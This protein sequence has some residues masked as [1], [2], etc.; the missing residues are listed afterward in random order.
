MMCLAVAGRALAAPSDVDGGIDAVGAQ[1]DAL[2]GVASDGTTVA[3]PPES[4]PEE[5]PAFL[6]LSVN[7]VD[8]DDVF[9][10]LR[11]HDALVKV[12]DLQRSG[13]QVKGGKRERRGDDDMV[14]LASLS[15]GV[16]FVTDER[17]LTLTVTADAKLFQSTTIDLHA[18]RP[19]GIRYGSSPG[20][21]VNYLVRGS[22]MQD[23]KSGARLSGFA[24]AGLSVRGHLL[25]ASGQRNTL[26]G[27][28]QRLLT[29]ATFDLRDRLTS[30]VLGD[31]TATSDVLGGGI[32]LGGLSIARNYSLDPYYVF[33][34]TQRLAGTALT[35]STVEVYVNGQLVRRETLSPGPFS[36][37]NVPVTTGSGDT[38]VVVRDAFGA[39]QT[40]VNPYYMALGTLAK[41][42]HDF[43]YN[44]GFARNSF[45]FDSWSYG[46]ATVLARHRYGVTDWLTVGGRVEGHR[47]L[48]S[49]GPSLTVRLPVGEIGAV[50]AVSYQE[51]SIRS[52]TLCWYCTTPTSRTQ[53]F[54]G[55]AGLLSYSYM[56]RPIY[57][58]AGIR[59]QSSDYASL[60]LAPSGLLP[61]NAIP[62]GVPSSA[63]RQR[64]D[65]SSAVAKNISSVAS[66]SLQYQAT[67][68]R[69][70]GWIHRVTLMGNRTINRW[71]YAYATLG[72][73]FQSGYPVELDTFF[74]LSFAP[75]D[76]VTAGLNRTDRWGGQS[77]YGGSTQATVQQSLPVGP[78]LGYR[79]VATQGEND[80]NQANLQYQGAYGRVEADYQHQG[81]G[82]EDSG[83]LTLTATGGLVVIGGR[84]F[85]SRTN[86]DSYALVR[87]PDVR[88]V[89]AMV[90]N[91][92]VGTTDAH[93]D[94]LIPNLLHYYGNRIGI[95]DK[96]IP[97]DHDIG[98][99]ERI[100]APPFRGGMIVSFPVHR[101]Q[102]VSGTALVD[103]EGKTIV[104]T[105]GQLV[106]KAGE[107]EV[108]SPLDEAGNFYLE[109][110]GPGHY[111]T[112]IQYATGVCGF[113]LT[114]PPSSTALSSVGTVTCVAAKKEAK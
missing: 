6:H 104:P 61:A 86:H 3:V 65:I 35:P 106:V 110:L 34:P 26:D 84:P 27:T 33:L 1:D 15:P 9:V 40:V 55:H 71:L 98:A 107:R 8:V 24:E 41:G 48:A 5:R 38:R 23:G 63:D 10:V 77:G 29:N 94:L 53:S 11:G 70:Q 52:E 91:Q 43:S 17:S 81:F 28:W 60:A 95:N 73:T 92:I 16:Q 66:L 36:M 44:L 57:L 56:G 18:K 101:V 59:Y 76:R 112:E 46:R 4:V 67:E 39:S 83:H 72:N 20:L 62:V 103:E 32:N 31:L 85:L 54:W 14:W 79:V 37:L 97:L 113:T 45:G 50:A 19:E 111:P 21:F 58:Q 12:A 7:H 96:D 22:E 64:L 99:T 47:H 30:V 25:Y 105:Y 75:A 2:P 89:H 87:V 109:D 69:E 114:V 88:G 100:I 42:L 80:V 102:S 49:G 74:G 78:G 93:G 82:T 90:S 13:L 51:E 108:I 68:W